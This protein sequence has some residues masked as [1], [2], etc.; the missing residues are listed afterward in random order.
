MNLK[1]TVITYDNVS[2]TFSISEDDD[3]ASE[4][5]KEDEEVEELCHD[6]IKDFAPTRKNKRAEKSIEKSNEI[7]IGATST[8]SPEK[9]TLGLYPLEKFACDALAGMVSDTFSISEDDDD[10]SDTSRMEDD[11]VSINDV[12]LGGG[13]EGEGATT[14][15]REHDDPSC[16]SKLL[17]PRRRSKSPPPLFLSDFPKV[18]PP[19]FRSA[20]TASRPS[21][22][23]GTWRT[24]FPRPSACRGRRGRRGRYYQRRR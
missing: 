1:Y 17:R 21:N 19:P 10:T 8:E 5:N 16:D 18:P 12:S 3:D 2:D 23:K 7:P 6:L 11:V 13:G 9:H 4:D 15:T 24:T 22:L 20:L 14:P